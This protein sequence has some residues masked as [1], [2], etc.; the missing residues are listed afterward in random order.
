MIDKTWD[1]YEKSK[2]GHRREYADFFSR[3]L[4]CE[5]IFGEGLKK[6][7]SLMRAPY[8]LFSSCDDHLVFFVFLATVRS[9]TGKKTLTI[10]TRPESVF[11]ANTPKLIL[12]RSLYSWIRKL[13]RVK[14]L[15]ILPFY[16][17]ERLKELVDDW[18][19]DPQFWDLKVMGHVPDSKSVPEIS[20]FSSRTKNNVVLPGKLSRRKGAEFMID[21]YLN[22]PEVR[23][24]YNFILAGKNQDVPGK[25]IDLFIENGGYFLGRYP[26]EKELLSFYDIAQMIWC[27]YPGYFNHSSG[28][29]GRALQLGKSV[30]VRKGAYLDR[31]K[32]PETMKCVVEYGDVESTADKIIRFNILDGE[33]RVELSSSDKFKRII[34]EL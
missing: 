21:I 9:C 20:R 1:G 14:A 2:K 5:V 13:P 7:T 23:E 32:I 10:A 3:I 24:K 16:C 11:K 17:E 34:Q 27:C 28:I 22:F 26:T 18:I 30:I 4:K 25:K 19:Y 8:L 6:Y 33:T 29:F 31:V 15:S 12:K